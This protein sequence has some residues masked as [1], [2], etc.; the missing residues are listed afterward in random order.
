MESRIQ[1]TAESPSVAPAS[2][3]RNEAPGVR[4]STCSRTTSSTA[5]SRAVTGSVGLDFV[6]MAPSF[7]AASRTSAGAASG[8]LGGDA[9]QL[10][11]RG[12]G[13]ALVR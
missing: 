6:P 3:P 8:G 11:R 13:P 9:L 5:R 1:P 2:S 7:P 4:V 12:Q 10:E